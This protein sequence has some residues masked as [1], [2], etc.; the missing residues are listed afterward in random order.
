MAAKPPPKYRYG[1]G[2]IRRIA[3][4]AGHDAAMKIALELGGK[5]LYIPTDPTNSRLEACVGEE[6]AAALSTALADEVIE[7]AFENRT[8]ARWLFQAGW[9]MADIANRLRVSRVSIRQWLKG[10]VKPSP[11]N[12]LVE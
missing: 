6:A 1:S 5:Q 12:D 8:L 3:E 4:I 7:V 11:L 9:S 2:H 10:N